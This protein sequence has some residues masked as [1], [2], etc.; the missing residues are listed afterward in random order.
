MKSL[1]HGLISEA[2]HYEDLKSAVREA[3]Q[4][5]WNEGALFGTVWTTVFWCLIFGSYTYLAR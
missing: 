4:R 5:A 3:K 2:E 1:Y